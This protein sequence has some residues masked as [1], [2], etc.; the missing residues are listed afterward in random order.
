MLQ[1]LVYTNINDVGFQ[2]TCHPS[3]MTAGITVTPESGVGDAACSVQAQGV[4]P[5]LTFEKGCWAYEI[6]IQGLAGQAPAGQSAA[7]VLAQEKAL[8]LDALPNL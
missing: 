6:S 4:A 3:G 2:G 5:D 8:A 1:V 7:T